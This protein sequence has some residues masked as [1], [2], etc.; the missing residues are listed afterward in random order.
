MSLRRTLS[1]VALSLLLLA[2]S[3]PAVAAPPH[4]H[5]SHDHGDHAG[6]PKGGSPD[7]ETPEYLYEQE[8]KVLGEQHAREHLEA[9][10]RSLRAGR[11]ADPHAKIEGLDATPPPSGPPDQVGAFQTTAAQPSPD[12]GVHVAVL[13]TGKVLSFSFDEVTRDPQQ[14]TAPTTTSGARNRGRAYLWDPTRGTGQDAWKSVPPPVID[15]PDG[16]NEPRPAPIF[17]TGMA[18]L[19][20]GNLA[21]FG[22]NLARDNRLSGARL[23]FTFDP[24]TETWHRQQDLTI[25]RWY[26]TSFATPDGRIGNLSGEDESGWLTSKAEIFPARNVALPGVQERTAKNLPNEV[27]P[28]QLFSYDYP[29]AF[30]MADGSTYV[31]GRGYDNQYK[32]DTSTWS[33]QQLAN[34]PDGQIRQYGPAVAL[35][36]GPLG[37]TQ[38]LVSGGQNGDN[39]VVRLDSVT[40]KWV[41]DSNRAFSRNNDAMVLLPDGGV[42]SVNGEAGQPL[43]DYGNGYKVAQGD[44]RYRQVEL[45]DPAS[46]TWKLGPPSSMLRGYHSNA[47]LLP[48]GRVLVTG[49]EFQQMS[50]DSNREDNLLGSIEI[51]QPPNLFRGPR[52]AIT[53]AP[54]VLTYGQ[55]FTVDYQGAAPA[56]RAVLV[57]PSA[58]THSLNTT[59]R[60]VELTVVG[61]A[62]GRLTLKAPADANAALPGYHMLFVLTETGAPSVSVP[63]RFDPPPE[64]KPTFTNQ[65]VAL[66]LPGERCVDAAGWSNAPGTRMLIWNCHGGANQQISLDRDG[67]LRVGTG[68]CLDVGPDNPAPAAQVFLQPCG[69]DGQIWRY[70]PSERRFYTKNGL[71]LETLGAR[72]E[73]DSNLGVWHPTDGANQ[74][75]SLANGPRPN[76]SML[77]TDLEGARCL[78]VAGGSA[79]PGTKIQL[80]DCNGTGAQRFTLRPDGRLAIASG[81]CVDHG[82]DNPTAPTAL[83]VQNCGGDGQIWTYNP[84]TRLLRAATNGLAVDVG[85]FNPNNGADTVVWHVHRGLNQKW[86]IG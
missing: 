30:T 46:R 38:A 64:R 6:V 59:Q 45:Y 4:D 23:V 70:N 11:K 12:Y 44:M 52:P 65:A 61:N 49:D 62:E 26:P 36:G 21:V 2:A 82:K 37:P 3:T 22:G 9:R 18:F 80:W 56:V 71:V 31:L 85:N 29:H 34:R 55:E 7:R 16:K 47:V 35:P 78:D 68:G 40:G 48:D 8:R 54:E 74:L 69:G 20:N 13:P 24:W 28:F 79:Q 66:D 72:G 63:V 50:R 43:R 10:K 32:I 75:W 19:P 58:A 41:T 39:S 25:G 84:S 67:R 76:N 33:V 27:A 5:A 81:G 1:A 57:T 15:M 77:H 86:S 17:C 60:H 53:H 73:N 51:Y 42:L 83:T 14:E